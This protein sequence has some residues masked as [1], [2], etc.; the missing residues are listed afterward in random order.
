M[1]SSDIDIESSGSS[2][3]AV[4]W[5]RSTT[6][7]ALELFEMHPAL[8]NVMSPDYRDRTLKEKAWLSIAENLDFPVA[9]VKKKIHNLRS[10]YLTNLKL[11]ERSKTSGKSTDEVFVPRWPY[12][13]AMK[14][15]YTY[16][17]PRETINSNEVEVSVL[18]F[19]FL[20]H[21]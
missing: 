8:Y 12:Y 4:V 2:K 10:Q 14:F 9:D 7:T 3:T 6:F 13:T 18:T 15:L 20:S 21:F 5:D 16:V 11:V 17:S 1:E 19:F